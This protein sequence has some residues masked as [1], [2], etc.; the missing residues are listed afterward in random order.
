MRIALGARLVNKLM[1]VG[2][3]QSY[4]KIKLLLESGLTII[5]TFGI[6]FAICG[7]VRVSRDGL[8]TQSATAL[9]MNFSGLD[10]RE[11]ANHPV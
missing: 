4:K 9:T 11:L 8:K 2:L 6:D 5:Y 10:H 7:C 3:Y 1:Q